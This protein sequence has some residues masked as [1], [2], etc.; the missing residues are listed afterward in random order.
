MEIIAKEEGFSLEEAKRVLG[1]EAAPGRMAL[2]EVIANVIAFLCSDQ[3][4]FITGQAINV[5]GGI[6]FHWAC[7]GIKMDSRQK[8]VIRIMGLRILYG[9]V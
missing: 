9:F 8:M 5:C 7:R 1:Q 2:P 3:A 4:Y 6:E